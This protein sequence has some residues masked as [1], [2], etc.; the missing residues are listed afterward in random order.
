MRRLVLVRHSKAEIDP[1]KPAASWR[2][3]DT[4]RRRSE[5]LAGRLRGFN[6]RVAWSSR[7]PKAVETAEIVAAALEVPVQTADG[8]EEHHRRGVPYFPSRDEFESAVEQFFL[9]PDQLVLGEETA[10]Q[11]LSRFTAAIDD[12]LDAGQTD[13]VVV[14][15]GTVMTLYVARVAGVRPMDFWRRLET[16]SFV[17]LTLPDLRIQSIVASSFTPPERRKSLLSR[18]AQTEADGEPLGAVHDTTG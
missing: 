18:I 13:T 6:L 4:G 17:V 15:H 7:E 5:L 10:G 14:T 9:K 16:P 8:L 3:D 2:L 12:V 1:H 11:A